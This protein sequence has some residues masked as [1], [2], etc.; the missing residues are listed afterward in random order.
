MR[1][2]GGCAPATTKKF[3]M[4][5]TLCGVSLALLAVSAAEAQKPLQV[6][7]QGHFTVGGKTMARPGQYDNSKFVGW[8]EQ[9]EAGQSYRSDHA[10]VGYQIP[11]NANRHPLVFVHGYGGSGVCWEMAPDGRKGFSTLMLRHGYPT[12][13]MDLPGRG[14]AGRTS[15]TTQV[16]PVADEMFWFDIWRIGRWPDYNEG[17]QFPS[18]SAYLSQFFREMTPDLSDHTLDAAAVSALCDKIE[19][20]VLVTHSAGGIPGWFAAM[21]NPSVRG[22]AAYEPGAYVFPEGEVP[23]RIDGLTGGTDGIPVP[24]GQFMRLT[25]IPIVMY[26]GDYIPDEPVSDLGGE[27]WRVRLQMGRK[28]AECVNRHGGNATLVELPKLGIGGNTHFLMQDLNSGELADLLDQWL[29]D[30]GLAGATKAEMPFALGAPLPADAFH[31]EAYRNDL[32]PHDAEYNFPQTNVITFA[33]GSHS[34]WHRHGGMD[35]LVTAGVGIYQEEGKTAQIVRR[36][37]VVHIPAGTRHWHGAA[38]SNWFQQVVVYDSKWSD[39]GSHPASGDIVSDEYYAAMP[40]VEFKR[41]LKTQDISMFAVGDSLLR[42]DTFSGPVRLSGILEADNASGAPAI[43]NVVFEPG[44]YN[45]WHE[46]PGGQ[47]LIVTDGTCYHQVEGGEV[48][49]LHAGD[50]AKCPPGTRHWHGAA[51]DSRMAHLATGTNPERGGVKWL[52]MLSKR[53]YD[54]IGKR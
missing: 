2:R 29:H 5:R 3:K 35:I 19:P 4:R 12:Y 47:I 34:N 54:A 22:V 53:R 41:R 27:N 40:M 6:E 30:N 11:V 44:T 51:P 21:A 10:A 39:S 8:A 25:Q 17:V 32:I 13:V 46:H 23:E 18:D 37:D 31:G 20:S 9:E 43:H 16:R 24:M 33:P 45:A 48:E 38:P 42:F 26:F 36:G 50:V 7:R 49:I 14:R 52:K 15:A 1:W 28:F